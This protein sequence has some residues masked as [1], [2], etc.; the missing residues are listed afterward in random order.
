M[1]LEHVETSRLPRVTTTYLR[2]S[3]NPAH[4]MGRVLL[5]AQDFFYLCHQLPCLSFIKVGMSL[6]ASLK[7]QFYMS[8]GSV[9]HRTLSTFVRTLVRVVSFEISACPS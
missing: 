8:V 6:S 4:W 3:Y 9:T 5:L 1:H 2:Y 7:Q